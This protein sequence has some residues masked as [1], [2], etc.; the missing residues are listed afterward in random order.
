M[1]VYIFFRIDNNS[2]LSVH[3]KGQ[4]FIRQ[5][6]ISEAAQNSIFLENGPTTWLF[7]CKTIPKSVSMKIFKIHIGTKMR[8][9][10]SIAAH[11]LIVFLNALYLEKPV[12]SC[13]S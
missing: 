13:S 10:A 12:Y 5:E 3:K 2:I 1:S 11:S 9:F 4:T 8:V 6:N 7:L